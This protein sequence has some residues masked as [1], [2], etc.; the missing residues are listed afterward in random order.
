[1]HRENLTTLALSSD[2]QGE[3]AKPLP[4]E[5]GGSSRPPFTKRLIFWLATRLGWLFILLLGHLTRIRCVGR[6]H[7]EWLRDNQKPF[8]YCI[9]HGK[10]LIPIFTHRYENIHAMVSLHADGE[11]IAQTLHRLGYRTIRGSSTR[12]AQRAAVEMIRALKQGTICAIMPDGPKGPRHVFKLGAISIAQKS[13]AY[14]L[15]FTFACSNPFRFKSWD[16]FTIMLPFSKSMAIYGEPIAVPADL[17]AEDFEKFRLMVEG[18]ML[19]LE[20]YAELYFYK[21]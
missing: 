4:K 3:I 8:I 11:M 15:P 17:K 6:E 16:R 9:W 21:N 20:K 13:G 1:M 10:I 12:G 14:L 19:E 18:K 2:A 5:N 7:F